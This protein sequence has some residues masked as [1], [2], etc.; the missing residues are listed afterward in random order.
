MHCIDEAGDTTYIPPPSKALSCDLM[1]KNCA[2]L[3][4]SSGHAQP[5]G[6]RPLSFELA[7]IAL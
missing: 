6:N 5:Q 3:T 1:L 7:H 2:K 4:V